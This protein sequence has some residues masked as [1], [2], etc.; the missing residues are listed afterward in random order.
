MRKLTIRRTQSFVACLAKAKVYIE[1]RVAGDTTINKVPCRKLG[2]VRNGEAQTFEIADE[3]L[4][5]F[6]IADA[7]SKSY[8]SDMYELP[9]GQE[10]IVLTG[11]N[12]FN[13]V[14]GNAFRFDNNNSEAAKANRKRGIGIG[15]GV[16]IASIA[17]GFAV[18]FLVVYG[19][20]QFMF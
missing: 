18:G 7:L 9:E 6:V 4:K 3:A 17:V 1:D 16:F 15:V 13:P 5:V 19:M 2:E 12:R 20:L 8:C 10:D 11:Q 14:V